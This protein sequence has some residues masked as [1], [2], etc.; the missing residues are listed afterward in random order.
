MPLEE[1]VALIIITDLKASKLRLL[2]IYL[3]GYFQKLID[4]PKCPYCET[5]LIFENCHF[6][7]IYPANRGGLTTSDNMVLI[8][9]TFNLSKGSDSLKNF[10]KRNHLN[11][12]KI[13]TRLEVMGNHI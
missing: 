11:Y 5:S 12:D 8:C 3:N 1:S 6:D 13:V 4:Y 9:S 2:K 10:A 7:H